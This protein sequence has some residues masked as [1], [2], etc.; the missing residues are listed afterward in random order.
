MVLQKPET[1]E[2]CR[3]YG[4]V[5]NENGESNWYIIDQEGAKTARRE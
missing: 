5:V 3:K 1:I 2:I 4:K